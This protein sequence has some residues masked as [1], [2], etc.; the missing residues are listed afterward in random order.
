MS[1]R[2]SL[3]WSYGSQAFTFLV[4]FASSVVIARLLGPRDMGVYA[5]AMATSGILAVLTSFSIGTY[6]IREGELT[7]E[8]M[9]RTFTVNASMSVLLALVL[10]AIGAGEYFLL[11]ERDIGAVLMLSAIGPLLSMWEF[12]PATLYGREMQY[13]VLS[14]VG[15]TT[16]V[17]IAAVTV[18]CAYFGLGPASLVI[19]PLIAKLYAVI[20]Y[21]VRRRA[22]IM[23]R[24]TFTGLKPIFVFGFQIMSISGVAQIAH[25]A[26]DIALGRVQG[27][28]GL[29][30]YARAGSISNLVYSNVYGQATGVIF[31]KMSR[32]L[33]ETGSIH[34]TYL[35]SMKLITAGIWPIVIGLAVLARPAV[36]ILYGERWLPAAPVLSVLMVAQ[37]VALGIGM[38][39]ELFVLRRETA[40]Q[41]RFEAIRSAVGVAAFTAGAFFSI[42]AAACGRLVD[43]VVAY[44]LYRP[45]IDRL[46]GSEPG[47]L[48]RVFG[49]S[50]VLT[51]VAVGPSVALMLWNGWAPDT[52]PL[53]LAGAVALGGAGWFALL[54]ARRH[55]IL[56]ELR[57]G[58]NT[59][60]AA[61]ARR[62][63]A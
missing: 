25:R 33:R 7:D 15:M 43:T 23:V 30:L 52:S 10:T 22:D 8:L 45:H 9:R 56:E 14:R 16:T 47:E 40:M 26:S 20:Y 63:A 29:G 5:I 18:P 24:P 50:L 59:I 61:R 13:G 34:R 55:P 12:I 53:L 48:E 44:L 49:E 60:R 19:G 27:L 32:D 58:L 4:T 3:A 17:I 2:T 46:A 39:W 6:I 1:V 51:A 42:T 62:A 36:Y 11:E 35:R 41:T 37:F 28:A 31:A 57:L 54:A 38:N 21:N